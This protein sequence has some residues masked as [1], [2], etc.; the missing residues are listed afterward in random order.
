MGVRFN[1]DQHI[2]DRGVAK[3]MMVYYAPRT[4]HTTFV[5][6]EQ[7]M[8]MKI[9]DA[10]WMNDEEPP[11]QF[12]EYSDD[13]EERRVKREKKHRKRVIRTMMKAQALLKE[14]DMKKG[15]VDKEGGGG[16][17]GIITEDSQ[18]TVTA[19]IQLRQILSID[20][21]EVMTQD[22]GRYPGDSTMC[23]G[24]TISIHNRATMHSTPSTTT[25]QLS[26]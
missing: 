4:E 16:V 13:E 14:G 10:S 25:H 17:E 26:I 5:F 19:C 20:Q 24:I 21:R 2:Q 1:N 11:P 12:I 6:L 3:G 22:R 7:L 18:P 8:K 23:R 9:S 15:M